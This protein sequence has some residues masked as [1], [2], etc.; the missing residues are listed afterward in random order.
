MVNKYRGPSIK[1]AIVDSSVCWY[2]PDIA[3]NYDFELSTSFVN[4][5][6][7]EGI[8]DTSPIDY[9]GHGTWCA[10]CVAATL[11]GVG[12]VGIA[13]N[14]KIVNVKVLTNEGWGQKTL[15]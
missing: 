3:S 9:Y 15:N 4:E 6:P 5:S 11:N 14:M 12:V 8:N 7:I 1:V 13:P 2:H 10:G